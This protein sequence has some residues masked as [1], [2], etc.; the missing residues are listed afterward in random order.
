[1]VDLI[2]DDISDVEDDDNQFVLLVTD[3]GLVQ[4]WLDKPI[5]R[6]VMVIKDSMPASRSL[7]W[8]EE[9]PMK[10]AENYGSS[11]TARQS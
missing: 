10:T 11:V 3:H 2:H 4:S 6:V 7:C 5:R 1:M 9:S 8:F